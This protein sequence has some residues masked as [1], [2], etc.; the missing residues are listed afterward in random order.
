MNDTTDRTPARSPDRSPDSAPGAPPPLRASDTD[1]DRVAQVL[2]QALSEG[3]LTHEEH[4]ERLDAVYTSK[5]LE[6]L[7]PLT[8]DLPGGNPAA[9]PGASSAAATPT[10]PTTPEDA[11]L[12][13]S[14]TGS[15]NIIA[16]L[17]TAERKG[18]WL[19]EPR[20]NV[21]T[22]LGSVELDMRQALMS[23]NRVVVQTSVILGGVTLVVPHGVE[24]ENR[25]T[26]VLGGVGI[27]KD[28]PEPASGAPKVVITG[29]AL[30]G[31]IEVKSSPD[32]RH[33]CC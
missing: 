31:G 17:S 7:A 8:A 13:A 15:E 4:T 18:R 20:T 16:V 25:V 9:A 21:S 5:T 30:L 27:E 12:L 1:R 32:Q 29:H 19:V 22:L 3:R 14:A 23:Q 24:I 2:S 6:E 28:R 11:E 26:S 33:S 10:Q